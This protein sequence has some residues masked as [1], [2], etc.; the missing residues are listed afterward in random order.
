MKR[1]LLA[2]CVLSTTY[3]C[4]HVEGFAPYDKKRGFGFDARFQ[5]NFMLSR[6]FFRERLFSFDLNGYYKGES[7]W[8]GKL[9]IPVFIVIEDKVPVPVP[10]PLPNLQVGKYWNDKGA[11]RFGLFHGF[12][13]IGGDAWIMPSRWLMTFELFGFMARHGDAAFGLS[14]FNRVFLNS[15]LY[16]SGG[17]NFFGATGGNHCLGFGFGT[18]GAGVAF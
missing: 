17:I 8:F 10:L 9:G 6:S 16:L 13:G 1:K 18:I 12:P 14:W 5:G 3:I 2:L 7:G 15:N 11:L 4:A